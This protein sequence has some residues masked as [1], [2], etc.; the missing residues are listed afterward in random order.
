MSRDVKFVESD[1]HVTSNEQQYISEEKLLKMELDV[2][3]DANSNDDKNYVIEPARGE[4]NDSSVKEILRRQ[5]KVYR[6]NPPLKLIETINEITAENDDPK[7]YEEALNS[8]EA[9][10]WMNAMN[11]EIESFSANKTWTLVELSEEKTAIG[12]KWVYKTKTGEEGKI[13][14]YKARLVA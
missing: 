14:R 2:D 12:C 8:Q 9:Q 5:E 10:H 11:E 1:P 7:S 3:V 4:G 6:S 13:I